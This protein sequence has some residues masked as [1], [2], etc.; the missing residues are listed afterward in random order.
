MRKQVFRI[1]SAI[2]LCAAAVIPVSAS[3]EDSAV[4][5]IASGFCIVSEAEMLDEQLVTDLYSSE[6]LADEADILSEREEKHVLDKLDEISEKQNIDVAVVTVDSLEGQSPMNYADHYYEVHQYGYGENKDGVL[7][8]IAMDESKWW[9]TTS[10]FG[11]TAITD[12]G[13]SYISDKFLSYLSEGEYEDAFLIFAETCDQFFTQAKTG[14]PYDA[15][16]LPKEP[17]NIGFSA[18]ISLVIG[19]VTAFLITS[20]MKSKLKTVRR[21]GAASEYM[22]KNSLNVVYANDFFLHRDVRRTRKADNDRKGGGS[23]THTSN[24]GST[25][26]GSGGSF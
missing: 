26:G 2:F 11:I 7:L 23:S 22:N 4:S 12:D 6:R 17:F 21:Q 9:M 18:L 10:G 8:L 16:N 3:F 25:F 24:S 5:R 20:V 14:E 13:I 19:F 15:G 1:L